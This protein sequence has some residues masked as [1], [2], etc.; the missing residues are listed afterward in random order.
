MEVIEIK[1]KDKQA[2]INNIK[3]Y[4]KIKKDS[5]EARLPAWKVMNLEQK[6]DYLATADDQ[7]MIDDYEDWLEGNET[8]K[9]FI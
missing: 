7:V 4:K 3:K 6:K 9:G 5:V 2:D 8:Y 1:I